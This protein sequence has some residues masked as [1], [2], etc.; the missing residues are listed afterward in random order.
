MACCLQPS[1]ETLWVSWRLTLAICVSKFGLSAS[2]WIKLVCLCEIICLCELDPGC[3]RICGKLECHLQQQAVYHRHQLHPMLSPDTHGPCQQQL[4]PATHPPIHTSPP[5][6][7]RCHSLPHSLP[8]S[9]THSLT[10]P[11]TPSPTHPPT[12]SL[13]VPWGVP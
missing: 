4:N 7:P 6:H 1:P 2:H 9:L 3:S 10:H 8:H 13:Q 11:L 5:Y 12:H